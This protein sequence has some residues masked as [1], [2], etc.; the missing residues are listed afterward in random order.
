L[1]AYFD[2]FIH[3]K[4]NTTSFSMFFYSMLPALSNDGKQQQPALGDLTLPILFL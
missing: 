2:D 4:L 1:S 3:G